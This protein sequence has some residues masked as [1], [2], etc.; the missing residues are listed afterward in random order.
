MG[1]VAGIFSSSA[2]TCVTKRSFFLSDIRRYKE[3]QA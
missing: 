2:I 1:Y 3:R